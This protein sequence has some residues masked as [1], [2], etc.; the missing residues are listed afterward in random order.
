MK[1]NSF[2]KFLWVLGL[3]ALAIRVWGFLFLGI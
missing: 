2:D 1:K 3:T